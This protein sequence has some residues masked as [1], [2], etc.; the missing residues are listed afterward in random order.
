MLQVNVKRCEAPGAGAAPK[1]TAF[2]TRK[3]RESV[4][5]AHRVEF[6]YALAAAGADYV[7]IALTSPSGPVGTRDYEIRL[8]AA[9]LDSRR[10]FLH[11]S[12]AYTLGFMAR[13]AMD[14]PLG[15]V[16][17]ADIAAHYPARKR[18][19]VVAQASTAL[20]SRLRGGAKDGVTHKIVRRVVECLELFGAF[21]RKPVRKIAPPARTALRFTRLRTFLSTF[22]RSRMAW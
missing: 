1:V 15:F 10:T 18:S 20:S 22:C 9:P 19:I 3:A 11:M 7:R 8:E 14:T 21:A 13:I 17:T 6:R 12:Y 16:S 5:D 2:I 4:E